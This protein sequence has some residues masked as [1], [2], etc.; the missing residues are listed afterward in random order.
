MADMG[1][2]KFGRFLDVGFVNLTSSTL[3]AI[4]FFPI[5]R[6]VRKDL[7][8]LGLLGSV[9]IVLVNVPVMRVVSYEAA[10]A[11]ARDLLSFPRIADPVV[12]K[13]NGSNVVVGLDHFL[14]KSA[15]L[16][17]VL[18]VQDEDG[19][20]GLLGGATKL[21][22]GSID[23]LLQLAHGVLEGCACV[24]DLVNDENVLADQVGHL[25]GGQV[26]PLCAG[27]LCAGNLFGG[28]C[29]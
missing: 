27:D 14:R 9:A 23:I 5:R 25:E 2:S 18:V 28:L 6:I 26:Q 19:E 22:G 13:G 7:Q 20:G 8:L 17:L 29:A 3:N 4:L 21:L 10:K 15:P 24:V 1:D 11:K 12:G 16:G